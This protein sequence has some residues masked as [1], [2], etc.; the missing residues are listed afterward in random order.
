MVLDVQIIQCGNKLA[1]CQVSFRAEDRNIGAVNFFKGSCF[2]N[3]NLG[4][5]IPLKGIDWQKK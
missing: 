4:I 2:H 3:P 5:N 1:M